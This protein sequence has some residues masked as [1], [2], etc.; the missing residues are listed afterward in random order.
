MQTQ[1]IPSYLYNQYSDDEDLQ[2]F[3]RS[4]NALAQEYVDFFNAINLPIY[5]G[6]ND[7]QGALLDWVVQGLYGMQRPVLPSGHN[8]IVGMFNTGQ[9]NTQVYNQYKII[10]SKTYYTVTDDIFKRIL[11]WHFYKGDGKV[12]NIR[13]LKRRIERFLIG[14]NGTAPDVANTQDVGVTFGPNGAVY[15]RIAGA[16]AVM[17][18][19]QFNT[20]TFNKIPIHGVQ[21]RI[22][23]FPQNPIAPIFIA[24]VQAGAIELP[25]QYTFSVS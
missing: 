9:F 23:T 1:T 6:V 2:A 15:I 4:Y 21:N 25:F 8:A 24:A 22:V 19:G 16:V 5:V 12:F 17:V 11:T 7:I 20:F 18:K 10:Q 3:V 14:D 13:W